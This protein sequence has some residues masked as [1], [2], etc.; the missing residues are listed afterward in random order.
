VTPDK[1]GAFLADLKD[2]GASMRMHDS[3]VTLRLVAQ[4]IAPG[5]DFR[6][7]SEIEKELALVKRLGSKSDRHL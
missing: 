4:I 6:W 5:G 7:L 2:H 3:I 1:V